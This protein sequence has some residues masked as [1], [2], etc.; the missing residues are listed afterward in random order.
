MMLGS[1]FCRVLVLFSA[2]SL[3]VSL[4]SATSPPTRD[5]ADP[6]VV[7][8]VVT[9]A[10]NQPIKG[11]T[12]QDFHVFEN[13]KP[14]RIRSFEAHDQPTEPA[15]TK[16]ASLPA[17]TFTNAESSTPT[18]FNVVLLDQLNTSIQ[19]QALAV[20]QLN[21]FL[22]HKPADAAYA[23][24]S[25]R[26]DEIACKP[27][28]QDL[29]TYGSNAVEIP[30]W[31]SGCSAM[32]RLLLVQG[33][34]TDEERLTAAIQGNDSAQ[35]RATWLRAGLPN[36]IDTTLPSLAELSNLL[37]PLPGRKSLL[38]VSDNFDAAPVP[39]PNDMWF[40]PKF[41]GWENTDIFSPT[42]MDHL[43]AGR[44]ARARVAVYPVDL[45]GKNKRIYARRVSALALECEPW[46]S[47]YGVSAVPGNWTGLN[48]NLANWGTGF[49]LN[50]FCQ[51]NAFARAGFPILPKM[52]SEDVT[53]PG[54]GPK[55][56]RVA[57]QTGERAFHKADKLEGALAQAGDD[58]AHYYT[59]TYSPSKAKLD[60]KPREI[61][62][63]LGKNDYRLAYGKTYYADD[64][65]TVNR[66][67]GN[68]VADV[69][70]PNPTGPMPWMPL[71]IAPPISSKSN[72]P[73]DPILPA[74]AYAMPESRGIVFSA[75][76]EPTQNP[77]QATPAQM[78]A[79][80]DF[81]SFKAERI[82][83]AM[84][85]LTKEDKKKTQHKGRTVLPPLD[86]LPAPNP[87]FLQPY[88]IDY[89][90]PVAQLAFKKDPSQNNPIKLEV[91]V[92]AYDALGKKVTGLQQVLD[93][94]LSA[95][96]LEQLQTSGYHLS[97]SLDV[98]DRTTV[99]RLAVRDESGGK[100]G[101]LEVPIWA[102]QS[103][104]R[105]KQLRLPINAERSAAEQQSA[106]PNAAP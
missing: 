60:G 63:V 82:A 29:W 84:E 6:V 27:Y 97:E 36:L 76:V 70:L 81:E 44:V 37:E 39:L 61:K 80:Q 13:K 54:W 4:A 58:A 90:I 96:E 21:D 49:N 25:L 64:P 43:T 93:V 88:S 7:D 24:F 30:N 104:Y 20:H 28:R 8:V 91:A 34:T 23:I 74:L 48:F 46:P 50:S 9:D 105:R 40:P 16:V 79:L 45:T 59:L 66:P 19:D 69:Y 33:F 62:V 55:L 87:V 3:S 85:N 78:A 12:E 57:D 5:S 101:S 68:E 42:Q 18:S 67:D 89:S 31:D 52:P 26:N 75:H 2:G 103:P 95:N 35:P 71:R 1:S 14:Q 53:D 86:L 11:L 92:L 73:Q 51:F 38:W 17:N 15:A 100:V 47:F 106:R 77:V 65:A 72:E 41:K 32:G 94:S 56:D 98:P 99:L 102:I 83:K 10:N 22:A